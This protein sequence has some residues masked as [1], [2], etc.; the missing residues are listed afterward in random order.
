MFF[1][2]QLCIK[3]S[4]FKKKHVFDILIILALATSMHILYIIFENV[5]VGLVLFGLDIWDEITRSEL[6]TASR[7]AVWQGSLIDFNTS[8]N[9]WLR[10]LF[11]DVEEFKMSF[12]SEYGPD[13]VETCV[14]KD[15]SRQ[16][17]P[18]VP[19][20][21][22]KLEFHNIHLNRYLNT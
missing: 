4:I 15:S 18:W 5:S 9:D 1:E 7:R 20:L 17:L 8:N 11:Y 2:V 3:I 19:N 6:G 10:V 13:L 14:Q 12:L 22:G 16:F 21:A